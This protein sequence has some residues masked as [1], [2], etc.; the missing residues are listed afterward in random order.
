ME[1]VI[2]LSGRID[3]SNV[4]QIEIDINKEIENFD[5][6]LV[7]NASKLEYISSAGLRV[8]L[9]L[10]KKLDKVKIT[11]CTNDVYE[12]FDMTGFTEFMDISKAFRKISIE[13][14]D[15][16]G[17]GANGIVYRID[18][19]TIVKVYKE[20]NSLPLIKKEREMARKAFVMQ[21]PTAISYDIVQVGDLYGS[22]FELLNAKSYAELVNEGYPVE[23]LIKESVRVLK[24]IHSTEL[25]E[26]ELGS[27]RDDFIIIAEKS[28]NLFDKEVGEKLV[29]LF[30]EI[31]KR[32]TIIHGDY[33]IKN[34]MMQNNETLLIDMAT[35]ALGHPIFELAALFATYEGFSC[36]A[37]DNPPKFVGITKEQC[38]QF[39]S[40]TFKEYFAGKDDA[41]IE[42]VRKKAEFICYLRILRRT[43]LKYG[44]D[45][46]QF[47][48]V[49][50]FCKKYINENISKIE[51][52]YF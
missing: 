52:L 26:H 29:K 10:K 50:D 21:I 17:E 28:S 7:L 45:G 18:N 14:C 27:I 40:G 11:N 34:I 30:K 20:K 4:E 36:V 39:V 48:Y 38:R 15:V 49:I 43:V 51:S 24:K 3:S 22:V 47:G 12:I 25:K 9:R 44:E 35:L 5:G 6:E 41:Y 23:Q 19:E 1:K 42:E 8:V 31:P 16:L 33:Q 37:Y 32:N 46:K 2:E 13:G